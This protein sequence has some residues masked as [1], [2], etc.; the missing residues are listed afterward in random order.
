M[1]EVCHY[2]QG[3]PTADGW[4]SRGEQIPVGGA[5]LQACNLSIASERLQPLRCLVTIP[6]EA[7]RAAALLYITTASWKKK[8][9]SNLTDSQI[10][11]EIWQMSFYDH[12]VC[13]AYEYF[14]F[15]H[16]IHMKPVRGGPVPS[17]PEFSPQFGEV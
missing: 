17:L 2:F 3:T 12:R 1:E 9:S 14:R 7:L 13:N 4:R 6:I 11:V 15:R 10:V 5:G 8:D 16:Y